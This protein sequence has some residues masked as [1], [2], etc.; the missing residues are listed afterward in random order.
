MPGGITGDSDSIVE[1]IDLYPTLVDLCKLPQPNHLLEGKSM[2]PILQDPKVST[3]DFAISKYQKGVSLIEKRYN[4]TAWYNE[5]K[6][7]FARM[8]Y[9]KHTDPGENVNIAEDQEQKERVFDMHN[10]LI[11]QFG[12]NFWDAATWSYGK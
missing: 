11:S 6:E 9:D 2:Q 4:Y 5:D 8:L 12:D 3:K 10:K 7:V 1:L